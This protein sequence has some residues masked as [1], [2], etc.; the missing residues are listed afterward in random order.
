MDL[1]LLPLSERCR[2]QYPLLWDSLVQPSLEQSR[3]HCF[4]LNFFRMPLGVDTT[5][6]FLYLCGVAASTVTLVEYLIQNF[7]PWPLGNKKFP[8]RRTL[9]VLK[10]SQRFDYNGD[11]D[12]QQNLICLGFY[13]NIDEIKAN[14]CTVK[15]SYT[16]RISKGSLVLI[17]VT[18]CFRSVIFISPHL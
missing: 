11:R 4:P 1:R 14:L 9:F 12:E 18:F 8:G 17:R 13:L 3:R 10:T 2:E 6:P 7:T 15:R 5:S 16:V